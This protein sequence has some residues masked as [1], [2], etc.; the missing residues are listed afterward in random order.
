MVMADRHL[1]AVS[2]CMK[3]EQATSRNLPKPLPAAPQGSVTSSVLA[4][5]GD[6]FDDFSRL[7]EQS[8]FKRCARCWE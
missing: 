7:I 2:W 4:T 8:W 3:P 6:Y 1:Q 5:L